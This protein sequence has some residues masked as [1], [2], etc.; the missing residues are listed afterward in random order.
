MVRD[1]S[2]V[3]SR[4]SLAYRGGV[5]LH[6]AVIMELLCSYEHKNTLAKLGLFFG[7]GTEVSERMAEKYDFVNCVGAE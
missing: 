4:G 3:K 7:L 5:E 6:M 2:V 1:D